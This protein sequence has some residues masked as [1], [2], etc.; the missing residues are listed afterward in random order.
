MRWFIDSMAGYWIM[1][2]AVSLAVAA[3]IYEIWFRGVI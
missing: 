2:L 1:L 3:V